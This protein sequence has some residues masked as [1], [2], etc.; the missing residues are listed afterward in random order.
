[1]KKVVFTL[2]IPMLLVSAL[3]AG[4]MECFKAEGHIF[5]D[6]QHLRKIALSMG[7]KVFKPVSIVAGTLIKSKVKFYPEDN[8][9][10]CMRPNKLG[11]VEIRVQSDAKDAGKAAWNVIFGQKVK[12][13]K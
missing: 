9:F 5:E 7:W 12:P 1:M 11:E 2:F 13:Q 3:F 4:E 10:V 6:A 8:V